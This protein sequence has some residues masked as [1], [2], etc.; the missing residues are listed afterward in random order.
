MKLNTFA[1]LF[2]GIL[3]WSC[4]PKTTESVRTKPQLPDDYNQEGKVKLAIVISVDQ[5]RYDYL[6]RF[7]GLFEHG[8][9]TLST[10]GTVFS[11]AHHEHSM[12]ATAPGHATLS[13]GCYPMHHGIVEN[14][15]YN[16]KTGTV[17]YGVTDP[18]VKLIGA[19]QEGPGVSPKNLERMAL[20]DHLKK[21]SSKSKVIAVAIKDRTSIL[22][23][24]KKPDHAFWFD[25]GKLK[26]ISSSYY[27]K[28]LPAYIDELEPVTLYGAEIEKGWYKK[29]PEEAYK[30]SREDDFAFEN[31]Q[32]LPSFPH[33]KARTGGFIRPDMK[34]TIMMRLTPLGDKVVLDLA[35]RIIAEEKMGVD[36]QTDLLFVGCSNA[37]AIGHHFGPMSQEVQDYYLWL[38]E[39]LGEFIDYLDKNIGRANYVIALSA[40]HGVLPMPEELSR[41]GI[42]AKRI[43]NKDFNEMLTKAEKEAAAKLGVPD[44]LFLAADA[45]GVTPDYTHT[46]SKGIKDAKVREVIAE[47][48]VGLDVVEEVFTLE[49]LAQTNG[50]EMLTLFQR[51]SFPNRGHHIK[52]RYKE[53]YLVGYSATGT[54]HGSPYDYD[55]NVPVL[56]FGGNIP[57]QKIDRKIETVDMAPT[58]GRLMGI[59]PKPQMDGKILLEA[60]MS[61]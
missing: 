37:D 26:F 52:M 4:T 46:R 18:S 31:G 5:M 60:V 59:Q 23:G 40:D 29:L 22:L 56:F 36:D 55:Q 10:E 45:S 11:N 48:I 57:A 38:D 14:N 7:A 61:H 24:G 35:K 25:N 13:T 12:T 49:T 17:D 32:F 28:T 34:N 9:K 42:D 6:E 53:N 27:T 30:L 41:K 58:L 50:G 54:S 15:F 21:A 8:L 43:L 3:L 39:Y 47:A 2:V 20:G 1:F 51:S 33:T 16:Q 44:S 19:A